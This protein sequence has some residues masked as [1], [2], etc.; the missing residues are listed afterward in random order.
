MNNLIKKTCLISILI[1]LFS[2]N[3]NTFADTANQ[4]LEKT[5]VEIQLVKVPLPGNFPFV[6]NN[7]KKLSNQYLV[8]EKKIPSSLPK[9]GEDSNSLLGIGILTSVITI[10]I[11]WIINRKGE[12]NV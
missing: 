2:V 11:F 12:E 1:L 7:K 9:T 5:S 6:E 3:K 8:S 4:G 10:F